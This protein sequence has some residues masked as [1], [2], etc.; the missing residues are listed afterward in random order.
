MTSAHSHMPQGTAASTT[1]STVARAVLQHK[2]RS[3]YMT[4]HLVLDGWNQRGQLMPCCRWLT[5][6]LDARYKP[7]LSKAL[8]HSVPLSAQPRRQAATHDKTYTN[9]GQECMCPLQ[10][11][12]H[13]Q[14]SGAIWQG[15]AGNAQPACN[16]EPRSPPDS[17]QDVTCSPRC[18]TY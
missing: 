11:C 13:K 8:L 10:N 14:R 9:E 2:L 4:L 6:I 1:S 18:N 16:P 17:K 3:M 7:V 15:Q 5:H 12:T